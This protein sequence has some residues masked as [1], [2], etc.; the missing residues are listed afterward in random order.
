MPATPPY[1]WLGS[2]ARLRTQAIQT[3]AKAA[4]IAGLEI[5]FDL[6]VHTFSESE[7]AKPTIHRSTTALRQKRS[8][9]RLYRMH[10]G[11]DK[12]SRTFVGKWHGLFRRNPDHRIPKS[13]KPLLSDRVRRGRTERRWSLPVADQ[14]GAA[15]GRELWTVFLEAGQNG[16]IALVQQLAAETMHVRCASLSSCSVPL[17][18]RALVETGTDSR[19]SARK[20]LCIVILLQ[21]SIIATVMECGTPFI[22]SP[23]HDR[24]RRSLGHSAAAGRGEWPRARGSSST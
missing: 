8:F 17:C 4:H 20:N 21:I 23:S 11:T 6:P 16:E 10:E 19:M 24:F 13:P 22:P 1:S 15:R 3:D 2:G 18:A 12:R 7:P 9:D 5:L 14:H